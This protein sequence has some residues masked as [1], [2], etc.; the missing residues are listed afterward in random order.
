MGSLYFGT[1]NQSGSKYI[2]DSGSG[3]LTTTTTQCI[4]CA[5][6][7]VF[8][9]N[10]STTFVNGTSTENSQYADKKWLYYGSATLEGYMGQDDVSLLPFTSATEST[11]ARDFGFFL[12]K[13]E[14]GL[15][16]LDG[17]LGLSPA[18]S[19]N[20]PSFVEALYDAGVIAEKVVTF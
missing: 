20:G 8:N 3:F 10:A 19:G 15:S 5:G 13:W 12:I 1:P 4:T 6:A 14:T 17:I 9:P 7:R 16:G 2:F 18:A 11:V